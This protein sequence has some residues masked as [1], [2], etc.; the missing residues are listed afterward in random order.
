VSPATSGHAE[1]PL[2]P[3]SCESCFARRTSTWRV[4]NSPRKSMARPL[5]TRRRWRSLHPRDNLRGR[6]RSQALKTPRSLGFSQNGA[7]G[8]IFHRVPCSAPPSGRES[9]RTIS[10]FHSFSHHCALALGLLVHAT[11]PPREE[12]E[13]ALC[14][15]TELKTSWPAKATTSSSTLPRINLGSH[16]LN[17]SRRRGFEPAAVYSVANKPSAF[18][19]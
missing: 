13:S 5:S 11:S 12:R 14:D 7:V 18:T 6:P 3:S 17:P 16:P 10:R 8:S 2:L 1:P 9:W 4:G 15:R 19:F